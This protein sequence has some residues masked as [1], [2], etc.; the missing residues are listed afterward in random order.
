MHTIKGTC[1]FFGYDKLEKVTHIGENLLVKLRDG[2]YS[3]NEQ[4]ATGL[5]AMV[6]AVRAMLHEISSHGHDGRK[7]YKKLIDLLSE[8]KDTGTL[9]SDESLQ[10]VRNAAASSET[11]A[12]TQNASADT[13]EQSAAKTSA[14]G[15][16][17]GWRA[18][19]GSKPDRRVCGCS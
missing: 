12:A 17:N 10:G 13:A 19:A 15:N 5:L 14:S 4:I 8:L 6:D 16:V 11:P 7:R 2:E 1:G 9:Q 3:M 18:R